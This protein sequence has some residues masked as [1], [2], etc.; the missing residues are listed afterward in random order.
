MGDTVNVASRLEHAAPR[1]GVLI[2][3]DTYRHVRGVFDVEGPQLH[4]LK[5][6]AEPVPAYVVRGVQ[7]RAFRVASRGVE[8]VET[9]MI[10]REQQLAALQAAYGRAVHDGRGAA[11]NRGGRSGDREVEAPGRARGLDRA[12][13]RNG[14]LLQGPRRP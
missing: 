8:G 5:G 6:K 13:A 2:S 9:R 12:A 7:P 1:G 3:H 11:R 14:R 4:E 10:G